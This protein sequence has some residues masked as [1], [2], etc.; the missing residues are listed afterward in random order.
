MKRFWV[1]NYEI[2]HHFVLQKIY[3]AN[4]DKELTIK[5]VPAIQTGPKMTTLDWKWRILSQTKGL[6]VWK[7]SMWYGVKICRTKLC[8]W[9]NSY[10]RNKSHKR[11]V[12]ATS[13][14]IHPEQNTSISTRFMEFCN[15]FP[16]EL[17]HTGPETLPGRRVGEWATMRSVRRLLLT[18]CKMKAPR[19][20][21]SVTEMPVVK[22]TRWAKKAV[23]RAGRR[24]IVAVVSVFAVHT[25]G[26]QT[27]V[28]S[29]NGKP[30]RLGSTI[31]NVDTSFYPVALGLS[32]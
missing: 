16:S 17:I 18:Q 21:R 22:K 24:T 2:F 27:G 5:K 20:L 29:T 1:M 14:N 10:L 26:T 32:Q 12:Q 31:T 23:V 13:W 4:P 15:L 9:K 25:F 30:F 7:H 19:C 3:L 11:D 6:A 8:V 28:K